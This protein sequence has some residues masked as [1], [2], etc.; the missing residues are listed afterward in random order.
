MGCPEA[1][2]KPWSEAKEEN[3]GL[4]DRRHF[5]PTASASTDSGFSD[6]VC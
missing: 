3:G 2:L 6:V 1:E 5:L 4:S